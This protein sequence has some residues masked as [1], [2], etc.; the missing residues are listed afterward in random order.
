MD[1]HAP[2]RRRYAR[3]VAATNGQRT[4]SATTGLTDLPKGP[5]RS[6]GVK[7]QEP[8][9]QGRPVPVQPGRP[10]DR[11]PSRAWFS[12]SSRLSW[13]GVEPPSTPRRALAARVTVARGLRPRARPR[14]SSVATPYSWVAIAVVEF[15]PVRRRWSPAMFMPVLVFLA[16]RRAPP[17]RLPCCVIRPG[18]GRRRAERRLAG[19]GLG[20]MVV[21]AELTKAEGRPTPCQAALSATTVGGGREWTG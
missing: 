8:C 12:V 14:G 4:T 17:T 10:S 18:W 1:G 9:S 15:T 20:G 2:R 3:L 13:H 19:P 5:F 21:N 16:A 6:A 11:T 7:G